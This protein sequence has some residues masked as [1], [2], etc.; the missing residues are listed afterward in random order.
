MSKTTTTKPKKQ[1]KVF[2]VSQ[3]LR[4]VANNVIAKEGMN[5]SPAKIEYLIVYPHISKTVAGKCIKANSEVKFFSDNDYI[6]EIS[7]ELWDQLDDDTRY[8]LMYHEL[9][10]VLPIMDESTGDY[11]YTI[12]Q[13]DLQDFNRLINKY[14]VKWISTIKLSISS[15][16]DLSPSAEDSIKI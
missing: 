13:H 4:D 8:V 5:L 11:K 3:E 7:G 12:R 10:H 2:E 16:Y 15:I 14:G 9:M 6:I 1:K